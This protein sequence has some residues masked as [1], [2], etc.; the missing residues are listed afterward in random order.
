MELFEL[1]LVGI[2]YCAGGAVCILLSICFFQWIKFIS[3]FVLNYNYYILFLKFYLRFNAYI[4]Q[5]CKRDGILRDGRDR[6]KTGQNGISRFLFYLIKNYYPPEL[7]IRSRNQ[8][9]KSKLENLN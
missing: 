1:R 5:G 7:Q 6:Q 4:N 8:N 2:S 9:S 3:G